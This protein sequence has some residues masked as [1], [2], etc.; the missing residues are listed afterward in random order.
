VRG[1][2]GPF[3]VLCVV[4]ALIVI[5]GMLCC[6]LG[7]VSLFNGV[8]CGLIMLGMGMSCMYQVNRTGGFCSPCLFLWSLFQFPT[9]PW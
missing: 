5:V 8:F 4:V 7:V 3:T 6:L 9:E 2:L 1:D